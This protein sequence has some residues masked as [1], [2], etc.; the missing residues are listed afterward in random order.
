MTGT[1]YAKEKET[2]LPRQISRCK[3]KK[4]HC[5]RVDSSSSP[6][7]TEIAWAPNEVDAHW[8]AYRHQMHG[9][10]EVRPASR[11]SGPRRPVRR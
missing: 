1:G 4:K 9:H 10:S 5:R 7:D 6:V 8:C 11:G 3:T 2:L